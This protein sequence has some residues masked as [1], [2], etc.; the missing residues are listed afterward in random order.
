MKKIL[1]YGDSNTHG[2]KPMRDQ[3]DVA[4][5]ASLERWPGVVAA[6]LGADYQIIEEGLPGRTTVHN[7]PIEGDH[8]NGKTYLLPCLESHWPLDAVVISLGVNDLKARHGVSAS[9]I[10][11]GVGVLV[12]VVRS[13]PCFG[14]EAPKILILA[15]PTILETGW[16]GKMFAGGAEKSKALSSELS[17][18]AHAKSVAFFDLVESRRS[19]LV[20]R[21]LPWAPWCASSPPI[22]QPC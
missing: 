3:N 12:D 2:T 6:E 18:V 11:A 7:D 17:A 8:K 1:C 22:F 5:F 13:A 4:R 14:H 10:A 20:L 16:L 9:D 21:S 15:A 19:S